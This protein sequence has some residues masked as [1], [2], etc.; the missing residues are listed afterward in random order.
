MEGRRLHRLP[1]GLEHKAN[2]VCSGVSAQTPAQ[3]LSDR[4]QKE[5]R[6]TRFWD[7]G[8]LQAFFQFNSSRPAA[9]HV[10]LCVELCVPQPFWFRAAAVHS[11][12]LSVSRSQVIRET[13]NLFF[14]SKHWPPRCACVFF[15]GASGP[16][17]PAAKCQKFASK[18]LLARIWPK[19]AVSQ[20]SQK[21]L[22]IAGSQRLPEGSQ[23]APRSSQRLPEPP[24]RF[25]EGS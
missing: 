4:F 6:N 22:L 25:P 14:G 21:A 23:K 2:R 12:S 9:V 5:F 8:S 17:T 19:T 10:H 7:R 18:R 3:R 15:P 1:E 13:S 11:M 20:G 16:P 24:K